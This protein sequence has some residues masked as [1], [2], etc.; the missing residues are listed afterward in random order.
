MGKTITETVD[1]KV[2]TSWQVIS[3]MYNAEAAGY[4][5]TMAIVHFLLNIDSKEGSYASEIAPR[6]GMEGSSLSRIIQTL[7]HEN[8]IIKKNDNTD[9]RKV[10]LILTD[11]GKKYKELAKNSVREFNTLLENKIGKK[12]IDYFYKIITEITNIA[13]ERRKQF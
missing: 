8:L 3:R 4:G 7:E 5:G 13:E 11:K 9:K 10:R 6:L 1:S 12:K 2:R